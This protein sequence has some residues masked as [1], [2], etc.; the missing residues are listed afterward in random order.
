MSYLLRGGGV[1]DLLLGESG[2]GKTAMARLIYAPL[3]AAR[4]RR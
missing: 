3:R 2:A 4:R 1:R